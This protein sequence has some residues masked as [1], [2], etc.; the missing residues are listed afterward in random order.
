[1]EV[2]STS[3]HRH[4]S[5]SLPQA[6][7]PNE[8]PPPFP[9]DFDSGPWQN[10]PSPLQTQ[11]ERPRRSTYTLRPSF[12]KRLHLFL[13]ISQ[14]VLG[15]I[16]I[17]LGFLTVF[18]R[19]FGWQLCIP[20]WCGVL[21]IISGVGCIGAVQIR[22]NKWITIS[23][24]LSCLSAS[25]TLLPI[26]VGSLAASQEAYFD[27]KDCNIYNDYPCSSIGSRMAVN[28]FIIIVSF[29]YTT[30]A[31]ITSGLAC[32]KLCDCCTNTEHSRIFTLSSESGRSHDYD[33]DNPPMLIVPPSYEA[34]VNNK[35]DRLIL[36]P[37][38][39]PTSST[40]EG[41]A[42]DITMSAL[43]SRRSQPHTPPLSSTSPPAV[44]DTGLLPAHCLLGNS[45]ARQRGRN[46][47]VTTDSEQDGDERN[48]TNEYDH[49]Q[50]DEVFEI[51][52]D[53]REEITDSSQVDVE[54]L[55]GRP[56]IPQS[57]N[58]SADEFD[59]L[60]NVQISTVE[61]SQ[62]VDVDLPNYIS[63]SDYC[64]GSQTDQDIP[65]DDSIV[66]ETSTPSSD[67]TATEPVRVVTTDMK[68]S[69]LDEQELV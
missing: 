55:S 20:I 46:S 16:S 35:D 69:L 6:T 8:A 15:T 65:N 23:M 11:P 56:Q 27:P 39:L 66:G 26:V 68:A 52:D 49:C 42:P 28:I 24:V 43:N 1:M 10:P 7:T 40:Q 33:H 67:D 50:F 36:F 13:S 30:V 41:F 4:L 53:T 44:D 21:Y 17:A 14:I 18:L 63:S 25:L 2:G 54:E 5:E 45:D 3:L 47:S 48:E 9:D 19:T 59:V 62:N 22:N 64:R 37:A 51:G 58:T 57:Q 38:V 29:S 61:S 12:N 32:R 60:S 31:F 34:L